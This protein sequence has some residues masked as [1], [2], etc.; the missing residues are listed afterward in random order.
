MQSQGALKYHDRVLALRGLGRWEL[1][2]PDSYI[3]E[4]MSSEF[5]VAAAQEDPALALRKL[6][7]D[8]E[9]SELQTA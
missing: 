2:P 5:Q 1:M 8:R 6:L 4:L 9:A 7:K 3:A